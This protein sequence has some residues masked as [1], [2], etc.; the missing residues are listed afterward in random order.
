[1]HRTNFR[2]AGFNETVWKEQDLNPGPLGPEPSQKSINLI[3][4]CSN[5][6]QKLLGRLLQRLTSVLLRLNVGFNA[7]K[8]VGLQMWI[9]VTLKIVV[10]STCLEKKDNSL[11]V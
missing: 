10:R 5:L 1:M 2:T 4:L 9:S 11:L 8:A 7:S 3:S 6:R